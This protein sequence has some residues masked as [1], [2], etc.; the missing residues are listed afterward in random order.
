ME[1]ASIGFSGKSE[2]QGQRAIDRD[3]D[4]GFERDRHEV[5]WPHSAIVSRSAQAASMKAR[6]SRSAASASATSCPW[7]R[8]S[9]AR[10]GIRVS[11]TRICKGRSPASRSAVRRCLTRSAMGFGMTWPSIVTCEVCRESRDC[12]IKDN[13]GQRVTESLSPLPSSSLQT[14]S[15]ADLVR[16]STHPRR[17][18]AVGA[19]ERIDAGNKSAHDATGQRG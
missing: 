18:N 2:E 4:L 12:K 7:R 1:P 15:P 11:G 19:S 17:P 3:H 13:G 9:S 5:P 14:P 6:R 10:P 8:H 16:G